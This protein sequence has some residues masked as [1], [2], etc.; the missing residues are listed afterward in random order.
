VRHVLVTR[1]SFS[2]AAALVAASLVFAWNA[3]RRGATNVGLPAGEPAAG[4]GAR[5][6]REHCEA[7]HESGELAQALL[8]ATDPGEAA[9]GMEAFLSDHGEA[10][11]T[12]DRAIVEHLARLASDLA[13][14][15]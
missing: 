8:E 2:I 10:S 5:A 9:R 15:R 7:C 12:E 1:T 6:F 13:R 11:A 4:N 14:E 3:S